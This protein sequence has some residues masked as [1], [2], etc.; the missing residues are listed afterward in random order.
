MTSEGTKNFT[1]MLQRWQNGDR[2]ILDALMP[3]I[4][5]ELQ[6]LARAQ[7]HR[8]AGATLQPTEL[9]AEAYLKLVDVDS[10]D[11]QS[12]AHF[13]SMAARIMR[14]ILVQ[15]YRRR[16]A[17]RRGGK[18]VMVT[19]ASKHAGIEPATLSLHAL[20]LALSELG[21]LDPRQCEIVVLKFFGGLTAAEIAA[22]L[23]LSESTIKREWA[24]ARLWLYDVLNENPV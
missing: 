20:D 5:N 13:H 17:E 16:S 18:Q 6:G 3:V 2:Q 1:L 22:T 12:R 15:R 23:D 10:V 19:L 4:Y 9:V 14:Q 7:I 8:D 21:R 24:A 11:W